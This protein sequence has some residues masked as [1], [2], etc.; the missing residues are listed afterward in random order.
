M[1]FHEEAKNMALLKLHR[2]IEEETGDPLV[3]FPIPSVDHG[4][5]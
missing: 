1:K 2:A 4:K 3:Q 5:L